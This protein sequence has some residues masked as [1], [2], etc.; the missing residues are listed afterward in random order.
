MTVISPVAAVNC[1]S[2]AH[3]SQAWKATTAPCCSTYSSSAGP[4]GRRSSSGQVCQSAPCSSLIAAHVGPVLQGRALLLAPAGEGL[5]AAVGEEDPEEHLALAGPDRVAVDQFAVGQRAAG[6]VLEVDAL[7]A[8]HLGDAQVDRVAEAP[9]RR[10]VG[11]RLLLGDRRD[12]VQ[13]VDQHEARALV[14]GHAADRAQIGEV[15][16]A[17]AARGRGRR[18]AA[19]PS[20]SCGRRAAS[21]ARGRRSAGGA[22]PRASPASGSRAGSR[23]AVRRRRA[24]PRRPRRAR[25]PRR[26]PGRPRGGRRSV[27]GPRG[28]PA[29]GRSPRAA[30]RSSPRRPRAPRRARPARSRR[31]PSRPSSSRASPGDPRRG[32]REVA[33]S[34]PLTFQ[35]LEGASSSP[36]S[37]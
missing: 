19:R 28:R 23:R 32:A 16:D 22:G 30:P 14:G 11:A 25:R 4:P 18:R 27:P 17:P 37:R 34:N 35:R 29:G 21:T 13:R 3:C 7:G 33:A 26:P 31:C 8:G 6:V 15:A 12:G 1:S 20:P 10:Q 9:G 2:S 36:W 24:G 5:P